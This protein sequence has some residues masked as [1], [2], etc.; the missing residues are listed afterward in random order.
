MASLTQETSEPCLDQNL[1]IT[2]TSTSSP[3]LE[4]SPKDFLTQDFQKT[5]EFLPLDSPAKTFRSRAKGVDCQHLEADCSL[6]LHASLQT[7]NLIG[8]F[9]RTCQDCFPR[10]KV[11]TFSSSSKRFPNSGMAWRGE[12]WIANISE[13]PN[14]ADGCLLLDVLESH[15]PQRFFLSPRACQGVLRRAKKRGRELPTRLQAALEAVA[16][17]SELSKQ[18]AELNGGSETKKLSK[19]ITS[20]SQTLS[21]EVPEEFRQPTKPQE[22]ISS[23]SASTGKKIETSE[24]KPTQP[25]HSEH[26]KLRQSPSDPQTP[27]VTDGE[28][29]KTEPATPLTEQVEI[30]SVRRLTPTE[31]ELLQGFPK[32]WTVPDTKH[33]VTRLRRKRSLGSP[34]ESKTILS[35]QKTD[36]WLEEL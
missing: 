28:F 23:Q 19:E 24:Q 8:S 9:V 26:N 13:S 3:A 20:S 34:A 18:T 11:K 14:A 17:Q 25:I 21:S 4:G 22:I 6:I 36:S 12:Y 7:L 15:A 2:N 10:M 33:W 1:L 16:Q 29:S 30:L 32:V 27:V 5:S 35:V 31:C